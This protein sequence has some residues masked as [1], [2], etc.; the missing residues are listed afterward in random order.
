MTFWLALSGH[1]TLLLVALGALSSALVV[2]RNLRMDAIDGD[3]LPLVLAVRVAGYLPWLLKEVFVA[4]VRVARLILAPTLSLHPVVVGVRASQ[5]TDFGRFV[6][7]N[8]ITLTPGT[9]TVST[10][11]ESFR[12]HALSRADSPPPDGG[13]MDRRVTRFEARSLPPGGVGQAGG[14]D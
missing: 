10:S 4:N 12:V 14:L 5:T 1:Y 8:S 7:A 11:G 13:A 2:W 9:V 3:R 6:H